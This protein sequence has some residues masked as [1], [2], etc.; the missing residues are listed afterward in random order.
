MLDIV[1]DAFELNAF[2]LLAKVGAAFVP[3]VGG[4]KSAVCSEDLEC[5]EAQSIRDLHEGVEDAVIQ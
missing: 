1:N 2:T 3:G 4:K 5:E